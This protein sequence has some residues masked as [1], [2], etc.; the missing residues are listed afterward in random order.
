MVKKSAINHGY[1]SLIFFIPIS[2]P[3]KAIELEHEQKIKK[4][5]EKYHIHFVKVSFT[6]YERSRKHIKYPATH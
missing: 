6:R 5:L 4:S 3:E 2:R 1:L